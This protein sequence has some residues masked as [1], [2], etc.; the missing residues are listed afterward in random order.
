[1]RPRIS[2]LAKP[3]RRQ[4][5]LLTKITGLSGRRGLVTIIGMR[6]ARTAAANGS[7][8]AEVPR[9]SASM[10]SASRCMS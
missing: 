2:C 7:V 1:L 3:V 10:R 9:I 4:N 6:V 5:A 8:P